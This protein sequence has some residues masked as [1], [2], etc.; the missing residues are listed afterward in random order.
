MQLAKNVVKNII[1]VEIIKIVGVQL[2][3]LLENW[4][5]NDYKTGEVKTESMIEKEIN[6][7]RYK[8]IYGR[9]KRPL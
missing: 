9:T 7:K 3:D 1:H 2:A 6:K 8:I 4:Q 5:G